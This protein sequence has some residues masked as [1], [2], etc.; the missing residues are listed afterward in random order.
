MTWTSRIRRSR[1]RGE[2]G[3][4]RRH[5][6]ASGHRLPASASAPSALPARRARSGLGGGTE[7]ALPEDVSEERV[8][9]QHGQGQ[10]ERGDENGHRYAHG[11]GT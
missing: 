5:D 8:G 2:P 4:V 1:T 7:A 9:D 11:I 3:G 10:H 6:P